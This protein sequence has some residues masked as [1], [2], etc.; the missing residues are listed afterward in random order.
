VQVA[1]LAAVGRLVLQD[2]PAPVPGPGESLVR[3]D[4][5]GICGSD[6]HWFA[7]GGI[8]DAVLARPLVLGHEVSGTIVQGP[9][10]GQ[11]VAVDPAV[12]CGTCDVCLTG[13]RNLCP[14]VRFAGHGS[15][16]GGLRELLAWPDAQLHPLPAGLSAVE[17]TVLEP[18]GVALHAV[19]LAHVRLGST[20]TVVGCG[21]IGLLLVQLARAAGAT[22]VVAV[23]PLA[24]RRD[25]ARRSGADVVVDP[26]DVEPDGTSATG[27]PAGGADVVLE[28]VGSP[29]R[30]RR[31]G[32]RRAT[33]RPGRARRHP[34]R[35]RD[36]VPGLRGPPQGPHPRRRA[37]DG[38]RLPRG[39][40]AG[41]AGPR[42]R[43][44]ARL[45]PL[46][47]ARRRRGLHGG[48]GPHRAEGRRRGPR[49]TGA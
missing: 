32:A 21:P 35:R 1:R 49:L 5:V 31:R 43:G 17:G 8:G 23:E 10:E 39:P 11:R 42:R 4:A 34:G 14:L 6:L 26:A 47:P 2:E 30:P 13:H 22:T 40:R 36:H 24:H 12:P 44:L 41:R 7:S 37:A 15:V 46:R 29:G 25:A 19:D 33:R 3:V 28:V 45:R 48:V 9:R 16:D 20:V 38:G 18:L 27:L